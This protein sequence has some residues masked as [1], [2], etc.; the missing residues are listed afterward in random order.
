MNL[1]FIVKHSEKHH[2]YIALLS[3]SWQYLLK[4]AFYNHS[5]ISVRVIMQKGSE[6]G[7]LN[8]K[9]NEDNLSGS[10][11]SENGSLYIIDLYL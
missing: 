9:F 8:Y 5:V 10:L 3:E 4:K 2:F 7:L 6:V 11:F 1:S